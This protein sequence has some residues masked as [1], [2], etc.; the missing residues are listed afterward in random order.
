MMVLM[1][2][3]TMML[4][5]PIIFMLVAAMV[6][7][8]SV[9][10]VMMVS[11]MPLPIFIALPVYAIALKLRPGIRELSANL[12]CPPPPFSRPTKTKVLH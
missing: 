9:V 3:I 2:V 6:R 7:V 11:C 1:L 5:S 8:V 10:V 4:S 12:E